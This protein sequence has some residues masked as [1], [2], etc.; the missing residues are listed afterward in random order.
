MRIVEMVPKLFLLQFYLF[1]YGF[2]RLRKKLFTIAELWLQ[3]FLLVFL[4]SFEN[5]KFRYGIVLKPSLLII[6]N[7]I[8][9]VAQGD[10]MVIFVK[11]NSYN[12]NLLGRVQGQFFG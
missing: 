7:G 3:T 2:V 9:V 4:A 10:N 5:L 6:F 11:L 8:L 12:V 1:D